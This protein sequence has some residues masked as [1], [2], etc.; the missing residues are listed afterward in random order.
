MQ[1]DITFPFPPKASQCS[2]EHLTVHYISLL[3]KHRYYRKFILSLPIG[4]A[5]S[6]IFW[7]IFL[8]KRRAI[9]IAME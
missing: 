8:N 7:G 9:S 6:I 3:E 2:D 5:A 1:G 4:A